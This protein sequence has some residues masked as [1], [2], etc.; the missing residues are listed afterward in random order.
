MFCTIYLKNLL[1]QELGRSM[2]TKNFNKPIFSS[3]VYFYDTVIVP[4][5]DGC[6]YFIDNATGEIVS[7]KFMFLTSSLNYF[8]IFL[9]K[10]QFL[11]SGP[12]F[13]SPSIFFPR[14]LDNL[15]QFITFG[16]QNSDLYCLNLNLKLL[17]TVKLDS[18]ISSSPFLF[19]VKQND[20][21]KIL[22]CVC[23]LKGFIYL[24]D[25]K[26]GDVIIKFKLDG[27]I[28]SSPI[29]WQNFIYVGC[30]DDNLYCLKICYE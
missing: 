6:I 21:E 27:E 15:S 13:N 26:N 5:V 9:K 25:S 24:V 22:I 12:I 19:Y 11:T 30:R 29:V 7:D 18:G 1:F 14:N 16:N 2:W 3:L 28:F 17:W 20:E 23:S 10:N 4:C 8:W